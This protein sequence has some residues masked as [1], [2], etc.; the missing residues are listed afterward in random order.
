MVYSAGII[1]FRV[2]TETNEVEFFV[3][4]PGGDSNLERDFWMFLKGHVE[5]NESWTDAAIREFKEEAGVSMEDCKSH[6]LIP[7]G[8]TKQNA[9]K[10]VIAY[11]LEY[12]NINPDE[13]K[14]NLTEFGFP[15]IDMYRWMNFDTLKDK[16]HPKH[17]PFYK[18]ILHKIKGTA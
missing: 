6:L 5:K 12:P 9:K 1:P 8:C 2:N 3:G 7:L 4:H 16:T 15:E 18:Q 13:C 10:K 11:A 17:L 14:S